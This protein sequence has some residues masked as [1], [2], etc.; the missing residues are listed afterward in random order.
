VNHTDGPEQIQIDIDKLHP[1]AS[2]PRRLFPKES[3][4]NLRTDIIQNGLKTPLDVCYPP[5]GRKSE[6][7]IVDGHRRYYA[8]KDIKAY[9]PIRCNLFPYT[10]QREIDKHR[11][12]VHFQRDDWNPAECA[13]FLGYYTATHNLTQEEVAAEFNVS[14]ASISN[15]MLPLRDVA[16]LDSLERDEI[17]FTQSIHLS[18]VDDAETRSE[19]LLRAKKDEGE[20]KHKTE[21]ETKEIIKSLYSETETPHEDEEKAKDGKLPVDEEEDEAHEKKQVSPSSETSESVREFGQGIISKG[22]GTDDEI[23]EE[24][25]EKPEEEEQPEEKPDEPPLE[26]EKRLMH[27]LSLVRKR[28]EI[29]DKHIGQDGFEVSNAK[30]GRKSI[31]DFIFSLRDELD[32]IAEKVLDDGSDEKGGWGFCR[33]RCYTKPLKDFDFHA[34]G[35]KDCADAR[36]M[37]IQTQKTFTKGLNIVDNI[38]KGEPNRAG[39]HE[40]EMM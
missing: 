12:S 26:T 22:I 32:S 11:A 3:I 36:S 30:A 6:F 27:D 8:L 24:E 23:T 13:R 20:D 28:I 39:R 31:G 38:A 17:S 10:T 40:Q 37:I 34:I 14:Q 18:R 16:V 2:Q 9:G 35:P 15:W 19:A 29:T 5:D 21:A 7:L 4:D 33:L 1:D 25:E